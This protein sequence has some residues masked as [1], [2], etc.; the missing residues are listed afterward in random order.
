MSHNDINYLI[1]KSKK[2]M[3][4]NNELRFGQCLMNNL[5]IMN[6]NIY[7]EIINT[8]FDCFYDDKL[9]YKFLEYL[10]ER[11]KNV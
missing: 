1:S 3:N 5:Q 9:I 7:E 2:D 11:F 6:K 10:I 4:L 8:E